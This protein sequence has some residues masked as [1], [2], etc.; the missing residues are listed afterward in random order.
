MGADPGAPT[1]LVRPANPIGMQPDKTTSR[2][3]PSSIFIAFPS[4]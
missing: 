2:R 4:S 3:L 1:A